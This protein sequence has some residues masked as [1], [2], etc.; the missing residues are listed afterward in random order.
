VLLQHVTAEKLPDLGRA[1]QDLLRGD[2]AHSVSELDQAARA[3]PPA[4]GRADLLEL[5]GELASAHRDDE[6]A[7]AL[8]RGVLAADSTGP[9][10]PAAEL[11]L[12]R[13]HAR[14]GHPDVAVRQLEHL[15]LAHAQSALVPQARRLLDQ[16]RGALP[17]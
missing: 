12:A 2:T 3:L 5:A 6:T 11:A 17:Q 8:L 16:L 15:I 7:A 1:L 9:A 14:A 10:A 13:L 4:G